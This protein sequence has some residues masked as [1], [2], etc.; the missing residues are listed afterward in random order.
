MSTTIGI[1]L[2]GTR[3]KGVAVD[4]N[5]TILRQLYTDTNDGDGAVWKQ[6]VTDTVNELLQTVNAKKA[7][8]GISAPGLPDDDHTSIAYMPG[9][10][11]GLENFIWK[12][13]LQYPAYVL[14]DA[15]AALIAETKFGAARKKKHVVMLTLGTGVGGAIL[16]DGKP[17]QGAFHK[18]G[19]MGHMVINDREDCDVT[20]MPGSLEQCIGNCTIA[21]RSNGRFSSTHEMLA[22]Y[23][24]GDA[25]A[26]EVWLTSVRRLAIGL[27]SITNILSP[28]TIVL[29]GGITEAGDDLFAPL[30]QFMTQ[31]EWRAG[32]NQVEIKKA[33]YGD[34]AGAIGAACFAM[35]KVDQKMVYHD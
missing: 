10:M 7:V 31:Y 6:A 28:Q 29:G 30:Q 20:G 5:G 18:A 23:R 3:I 8:I 22:A 9:R 4:T 15:V 1:D 13:Y 32:G 34:L 27:S 24:Q 12:D 11:P 26:K 25:F 16:I 35:S 17:Y 2:G 21:Q 14:N 19:H 33:L